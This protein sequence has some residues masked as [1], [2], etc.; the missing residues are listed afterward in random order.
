MSPLAAQR[1]DRRWVTEQSLVNYQLIIGWAQRSRSCACW[2]SQRTRMSAR[3]LYLD[4]RI[5]RKWAYLPGG[6][7][8][9][10]DLMGFGQCSGRGG[11]RMFGDDHLH[12]RKHLR[13]LA[14]RRS[15]L[16]E[17]DHKWPWP[18]DRWLPV[19]R[20]ERTGR[21]MDVGSRL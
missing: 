15:N 18:V 21:R 7:Q 16:L 9:R 11:G 17:A 14:D 12:R 10:P 19:A 4:D 13:V 8:N 2:L 3:K 5:G 1:Q 20:V 6:C